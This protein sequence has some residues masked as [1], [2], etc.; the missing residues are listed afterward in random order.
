MRISEEMLRRISLIE[1]SVVAWEPEDNSGYY[2]SSEDCEHFKQKLFYLAVLKCYK[3]FGF[4]NNFSIVS[5]NLFDMGRDKFDNYVPELIFDDGFND[6]FFSI[7]YEFQLSFREWNKIYILPLFEKVGWDIIIGDACIDI[8]NT[9]E[10]VNISDDYSPLYMDEWTPIITFSKKWENYFNE[11]HKYP[12]L[13]DT[14]ECNRLFKAADFDF[15]SVFF[16]E[17]DEQCAHKG[18]MFHNMGISENGSELSYEGV[19][20]IFPLR[21]LKAEYYMWKFAENHP[22]T[23]LLQIMVSGESQPSVITQIAASA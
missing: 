14:P 22:E 16:C 11:L 20:P 7:R 2:V 23:N 19:S 6:N 17:D 18:L 21:V 1:D 8:L 13:N 15:F 9:I 5:E 4:L 3:D 12:E 10:G